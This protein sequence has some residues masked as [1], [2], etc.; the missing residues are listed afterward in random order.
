MV[1]AMPA[2]RLDELHARSGGNPLFLLA[3]AE[4]DAA[5]LPTTVREAVE[6][7]ASALGPA[8]STVRAA[9]V[10]GTEIDLD[11]L[12]DVLQR[13]AVE[14]LA[15]LEVAVA[16]GL[17]DDGATGLVFRH[18]LVREA[19]D[20][21]AGSARRAL[22]HREAGRVLTGRP[23]RDPLAVA[24]HARLGGEQD[25]AVHAYVEAAL[26]AYARFDTDVARQL[27]DAAVELGGS[28]A[29]YIARARVH[30]A[31]FELDRAAADAAEAVV[32]EGGASAFEVS[33]WVAYYRR[34]FEEALA[35]AEEGLE[36]AGDDIALRTSCLAV[37]GRVHHGAGDL[38]GAT[39]L[40]AAATGGPLPVQGV[41]DVWLA[42]TRVHQGDAAAALSLL[43]RPLVDPDHL[44]HPWAGLH[45]RF[46]RVMAL[47]YLGR[48]A[49]AFAACDALE[50][51]AKRSGVAGERFSGP[52]ANV[53]AWLLRHT[54]SP[55]EADELNWR[56][57]ESTEGPHGGPR[58]DAVSEYHYV[59]LLDLADGRLL[60]G[61]KDE[62]ARLIDRLAPMDRWTG[63]MAW[64]QRHR[65]GL[66]R[67]R[68]ALAV[69]DTTA[70]A[71]LATDVLADASARGA[72]RYEVLARAWLAL[73]D[74][75]GD[76]DG[77]AD[78]VDGLERCAAMEGWRLV[79]QLADRYDV[80]AWRRE[81]ARRA[82]ALVDA[83]GPQAD[84]LARVVA[85]T[86]G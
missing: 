52:T 30:I 25:R 64:H 22:V 51:A 11:L 41:A 73:A 21:A 65:L 34:R 59:G 29:A 32:R 5:E 71:E 33:A 39:E 79:A 36:R 42:Y 66:L 26:E 47:G 45:G 19:L 58:S 8:A 4:S 44:A 53:R 54:G 83:A 6:R 16:N 13:P 23:A 62:A 86:N 67:A 35:F 85:A 43:E 77:L 75:D 24:V 69:G 12:A 1:G 18:E 55:G 9:A 20:Q 80:D 46:A 2:D 28:A 38:S 15:D 84:R 74:R 37:A 27:L 68:L 7:Q 50:A 70:A 78:V 81:A 14:V 82:T 76:R 61:D 31:S 3:L 48:P 72:R 60:A 63:T 17:L 49:D 10:L 56:V 40:L 57:V